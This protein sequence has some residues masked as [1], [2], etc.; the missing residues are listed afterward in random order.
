MENNNFNE[1][2][3]KFPMLYHLDFHFECQSG[4]YEIINKLSEN[5][6]KV[7]NQKRFTPVSTPIIHQVKEKYGTLR[8]YTGS[9][10]DEIY[11]LIDETESDSAHTCE[12]CGSI[13][14]LT[15]INKWLK[16]LCEIHYQ[17]QLIHLQK[18]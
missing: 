5:I 1:L 16:T 4:W 9:S 8:V 2:V 18:K 11:N 13:G 15:N 3:K 7:I 10:I 17:E 14:K 6:M 12:I